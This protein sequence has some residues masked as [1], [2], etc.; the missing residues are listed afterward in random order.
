[1]S[2]SGIIGEAY[3]RNIHASEVVAID[4]AGHGLCWV[5][6]TRFGARVAPDPLRCPR[7]VARGC[8]SSARYRWASSRTGS[9]RSRCEPAPLPCPRGASRRRHLRTVHRRAG[10]GAPLVSS[11][12][13]VDRE[14]SPHPLRR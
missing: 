12:P 7:R 8:G 2:D 10:R 6:L 1:M 5:R 4:E 9:R 13:S 3:G 14:P 11:P